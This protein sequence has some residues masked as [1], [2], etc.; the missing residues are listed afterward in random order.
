MLQ[1]CSKYCILSEDTKYKIH[2]TGAMGCYGEHLYDGISGTL[3]GINVIDKRV[4]ECKNR[5]ETNTKC[6]YFFV[7]SAI[8]QCKLYQSCDDFEPIDD[9]GI[10]FSKQGSPIH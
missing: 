6:I 7:N 3:T 10:T 2:L 8:N 4:S 1:G 5:C 9:P